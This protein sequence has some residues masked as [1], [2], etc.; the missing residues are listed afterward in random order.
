MPATRETIARARALRQSLSPPEARLW[1]HL[2]ALRQ[3]GHHFRRQAPFRAY[4]LDFVCHA[5][6]LAIELDGA[7]HGTEAQQAHDQTR[8]RVLAQQ[9]YQTLR[10]PAAE[11]MTNPEGIVTAIREALNARPKRP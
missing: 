4:I 1:L 5:A 8:D 9:G 11:M 7:H 10:L 3:E 2:K 6:R